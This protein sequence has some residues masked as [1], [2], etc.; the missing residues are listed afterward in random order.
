LA[1]QAKV[2]HKDAAVHFEQKIFAAPPDTRNSRATQI[3]LEKGSGL[4]ARCNW[5]NYFAGANRPARDQRSQGS[6]DRF[7]LWSFWHF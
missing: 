3:F 4:R 6:G 1:I 2:K 7:N 5:M